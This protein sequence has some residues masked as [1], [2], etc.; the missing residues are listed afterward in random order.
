M[1]WRRYRFK[2]ASIDDPRPLVF[3]PKFPWWESG[4]N[5]TH[6][7]IIAWLPLSEDLSVYWDDATDIE[8]TEHK[9]IEFSDR[10]PKPEYFQE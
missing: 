8:F 6:A 4:F 2:T 3:N 1:W 10:F 5:L 9:E 7:T